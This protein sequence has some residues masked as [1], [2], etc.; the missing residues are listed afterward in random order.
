MIYLSLLILDPRSRQ[1]QAELRDPYQTHRTLSRAFCDD[2]ALYREARCLFRVDER[3]CDPRPHLL[4][5]SRTPPDWT[6]LDGIGRYLAEPVQ[7]RRWQPRLP[8]GQR[9]AFRLRANP[10]VKRAGKRVPLRVSPDEARAAGRNAG[11]ETERL[12]EQWLVRKGEQCGFA[13][14]R[15]HVS[16]E[17]AQ[18]G[19]TAGRSDRDPCGVTLHAVR[20]DGVLRVTDAAA[21]V[22]ALES[23]IG[24]AKGFGFG[25]LSVARV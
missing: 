15:L 16:V 2:P 4:V 9:L 10:T 19:R 11:E 21:F 17:Q 5:Q 1:V 13:I 6:A 3:E 14:E 20:F 22:H 7:T 12:A 18:C 8:A 23:G 25:L 24:P